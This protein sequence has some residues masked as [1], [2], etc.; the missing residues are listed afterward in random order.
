MLTHTF[1]CFDFS[2]KDAVE[3]LHHST[4]LVKHRSYRMNE[5]LGKIERGCYLKTA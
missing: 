2:L 4:G 5:D 1:K 3:L